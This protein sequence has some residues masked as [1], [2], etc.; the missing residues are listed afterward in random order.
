MKT[1]TIMQTGVLVLTLLSAGTTLAADTSPAK[2]MGL[3][4]RCSDQSG[5]KQFGGFFYFGHGNT[6][7]GILKASYYLDQ[8]FKL[9]G[10]KKV[11]VI[12]DKKNDIIV[13]SGKVASEKS[14]SFNLRFRLKRYYGIRSDKIT[15]GNG[16]SGTDC[17][18]SQTF[19]Y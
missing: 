18:K 10:P 19:F 12:F 17:S 5:N 15:I 6:A 8:E 2:K 14:Q 9:N 1:Y 13:A 4:V 11:N 7:T 16:D 3:Q